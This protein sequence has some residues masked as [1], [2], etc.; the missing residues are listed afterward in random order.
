MNNITFNV[1]FYIYYI[2]KSMRNLKP[3]LYHS[4]NKKSDEKHK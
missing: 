4:N 1:V 2:K 3:I